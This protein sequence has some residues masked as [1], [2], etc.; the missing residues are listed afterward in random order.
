MDEVVTEEIENV[1][2]RTGEMQAEFERRMKL[3]EKRSKST[4]PPRK[5]AKGL[6]KDVD[7][8]PS[9]EGGAATRPTST[10][11]PARP[12]TARRTS[13]ARPAPAPATPR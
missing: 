9:S 6:E 4:S 8:E 10:A 11:R 12:H 13:F 5:A 1:N 2:T 3:L 7:T